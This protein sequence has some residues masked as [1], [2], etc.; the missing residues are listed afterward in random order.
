MSSP[1]GDRAPGA[2]GGGVLE[3]NALSCPAGDRTS[4]CAA[5]RRAR[6]IDRAARRMREMRENEIALLCRSGLARGAAAARAHYDYSAGSDAR[7]ER[8]TSVR[9][10]SDDV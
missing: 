7:D 1:I 4:T 10:A 9:L 5:A 6:V 8:E 3:A 2:T